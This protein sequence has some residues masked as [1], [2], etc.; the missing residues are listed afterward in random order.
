MYPR[1]ALEMEPAQRDGLHYR[2][3]V[4]PY[5]GIRTPVASLGSQAGFKPN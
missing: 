1:T 3:P 2:N 4:I 5:F